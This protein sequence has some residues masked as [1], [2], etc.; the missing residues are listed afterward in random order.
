MKEKTRSRPA[1]T[2]TDGAKRVGM[3]D[4]IAHEVSWVCGSVYVGNG[5]VGTNDNIFFLAN[6]SSG[7]GQLV[8]GSETGQVPIL[9][10]DE[11]IGASYVRDIEK[12]FSRKVIRKLGLRLISLDPSTANSMMVMVAPVRGCGAAADTVLSSAAG[13]TAPTLTNVLAMQGAKSFSS[14]ESGYLDLTKYI[15]GG[16]GPKQNEFNINA[17][18]LG[19]TSWGIGNMDL[20]GLSPCGFVVTG[21]NSTA[22]LRGGN[23]HYVVVEAVVDFLD[24]LGGMPNNNPTALALSKSD[25]LFVLKILMTSGTKNPSDLDLTR[26]LVKFVGK[27][28]L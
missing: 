7:A 22:G 10:S 18:G 25:A 20:T 23:T 14:Y 19:P 16:F 3:K 28:S 12:Y 4:L 11:T 1:A 8:T 26:K 24:F 13:A 9:G 21:R 2:V 27:D 6:A 5:S 17:D 15:A